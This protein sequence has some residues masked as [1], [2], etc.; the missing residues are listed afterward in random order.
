MDEQDLVNSHFEKA[1]LYWA[2]VYEREDDLTALM[3]QQRLLS[4]LRLLKRISMPPQERV[5]EV[6]CGAGHAAVALAK[7]GYF[8]DALDAVQVMVDAAHDR[9]V[10]ANVEHLVRSQV[11]DVNALCFP[12]ETFGL[13]FA[14]GVLPWLPSMERAMREMCRV[15]RPGGYL[16][17]SVGNRWGL[18]RFLDP[19]AN[20][21]LRPARQLVKRIFWRGKLPPEPW[22]RL[23]SIGEWDALLAANRLDKLD[24][25]TFGFGPFTFFGYRLLPHSIG[26]GVD[27][28]LTAWADRGMPVLR[29]AGNLYTVLG[30]KA[31]LR[32]AW[33]ADGPACGGVARRVKRGDS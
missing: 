7:L 21:S 10:K 17:I 26:V 12:D 11:G 5:L 3:Y 33:S 30:K 18:S 31:G 27:R 22:W 16:I 2:E 8:V 9:A 4:M 1:A 25:V 19:F 13:V 23:M 32:C 28:A 20:A 24:G 6:G 14:L 15:L 29:S